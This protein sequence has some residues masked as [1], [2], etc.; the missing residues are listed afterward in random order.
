MMGMAVAVAVL[1]GILIDLV[2]STGMLVD[3]EEMTDTIVIVLGPT[4]AKVLEDSDLGHVAPGCSCNEVMPDLT[5]SPLD[6][7]AKRTNL[8]KVRNSALIVYYIR[9]RKENLGNRQSHSRFRKDKNREIG[10]H[11]SRPLE[12]SSLVRPNVMPIA[13]QPPTTTLGQ[14][15]ATGVPPSTTSMT[16]KET[17]GKVTTATTTPTLTLWSAINAAASNGTTAPKETASADAMA[18]CHGLGSRSFS[19]SSFCTANSPANPI[20]TITLVSSL[21]APTP[22]I[23]DTMETNPSLA[24]RTAA[25]SHCALSE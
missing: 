19:A 20:K 17:K 14:D 18:A 11:I 22:I 12:P 21:T 1:T 7:S 2:T 3:V 5:S 13:I 4:I 15:L 10:N 24:P 16:P 6:M 8:L 25:R 23:N 9:S